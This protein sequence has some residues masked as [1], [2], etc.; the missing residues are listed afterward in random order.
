M[1]FKITLNISKTNYPA[2]HSM[3]K[4]DLDQ[5]IV[6]IFK[7]GYDIY[8]PSNEKIEHQIAQNEL[9]EMINIM[10]DELKN[11]ISNSSITDK[12]NSFETLLSKL[13]G[14]SSNSQKKGN[15]AENVLEDIFSK[16][17]GDIQFE[18]KSG[19]AHSGDAWLILPNDKKIILESKNYATTINKEEVKKLESDMINHHIKWGLMVSFNSQIQGMKEMDIHSFTHNNETYYV[20][21]ISNL[22]EE[23]KKLDLGIQIIR[24]LMCNIDDMDQF[25]WI[26]KDINNSLFELEQTVQLNYKLRDD[27]NTMDKEIN[28][29]LLFFHKKLRDYQYD[30]EKK[31]KEII[32]KIKNTM[33]S[34]IEDSKDLSNNYD[35]ILEEY[36]DSKNIYNIN[37][38]I[39]IFQKKK[40][41]IDFNA[42]DKKW[43]IYNDICDNIG[44]LKIQAKKLLIN[45]TNDNMTVNIVLQLGEEKENKKHFDILNS[46]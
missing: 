12:M 43:Y 18:R 26:V 30:I 6:K 19:T 36:K 29:S 5:T 33:T 14:L 3:K 37:R 4:K 13:I 1:D 15:F 31:V 16:R 38:I 22:A 46:L 28:N 40:W 24:T 8:Y 17:Y 42:D 25:P 20:V 41:V 45:I 7:T 32:N 27:Y 35:T 44:T 34:S 39:D 9:I 23:V 10:K 11:E 2:L 21:M